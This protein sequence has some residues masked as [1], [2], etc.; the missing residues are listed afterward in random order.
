[1]NEEP[2]EDRDYLTAR[3]DTWD[4]GTL[5]VQTKRAIAERRNISYSYSEVSDEDDREAGSAYA[6]RDRRGSGEDLY[7]T[8][9]ES[10]KVHLNVSSPVGAQDRAIQ[11]T[12]IESSRY[13]TTP[14]NPGLFLES[15]GLH[16]GNTP[17]R[18]NDIFTLRTKARKDDAGRVRDLP[19]RAVPS[20][21]VRR[22]LPE[23]SQIISRLLMPVMAQLRHQA[24]GYPAAIKSIDKLQD[25]LFEVEDETNGL[26]DTFIMNLIQKSNLVGEKVH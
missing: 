6:Q 1:M 26:V 8:I 20:S 5:G 13:D 2:G 11:Y 10:R 18:S 22:D 23:H 12:D 16:A 7:A 25:C 14:S 3:Q 15:E 9:K 21:A 17:N 4:F 19:H 24:I